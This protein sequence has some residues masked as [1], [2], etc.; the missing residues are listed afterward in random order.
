MLL[1]ESAPTFAA[2]AQAHG[3]TLV[4][5]CEPGLDE[6]ALIASLSDRFDRVLAVPPDAVITDPEF[7]PTVDQSGGWGTAV[8]R[9]AD[10][11][12]AT[13]ATAIA[14]RR[15][16]V[17]AAN[18]ARFER[19]RSPA[20]AG[21]DLGPRRTDVAVAARTLH[22]MS[23]DELRDVIR[24]LG[25]ADESHRDRLRELL[26]QSEVAVYEQVRVERR[27]GELVEQIQ[28]LEAEL[29]AMRNSKLFRAVA[30]LRRVY[31]KLRGHGG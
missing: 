14:V 6:A 3:W 10:G 31:G 18:P 2:A 24:E 11:E 27:T 25:A 7:D 20:A 29:A 17:V 5:S 13:R 12:L 28:R 9:F 1:T 16:A 30:P 21:V 19:L 23:P 26:D 4:L 22:D 15:D 8:E